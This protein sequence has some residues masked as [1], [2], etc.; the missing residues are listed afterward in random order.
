M[1]VAPDEIYRRTSEEDREDRF[2]GGCFRRSGIEFGRGDQRNG[3]SKGCSALRTK[4]ESGISASA[5]LWA[6]AFGNYV[7]SCVVHERRIIRLRNERNR[8]L[9]SYV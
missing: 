2:C 3:R 4:D 8:D 5:A 7:S 1:D 9:D 6:Y